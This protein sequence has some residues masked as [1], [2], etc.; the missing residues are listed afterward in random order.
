GSGERC[1]VRLLL[2]QG[3]TARRVATETGEV[4][5]RH[6]QVEGSVYACFEL[7]LPAPTQVWIEYDF[8][9]GSLL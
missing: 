4:A 3:A 9:R 8:A 5:F 2:P 7:S 1:T 6:E